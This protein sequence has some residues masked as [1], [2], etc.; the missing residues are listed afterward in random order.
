MNARR[1]TLTTAEQALF[2]TR[3]R[4]AWR[5]DALEWLEHHIAPDAP[6]ALVGEIRHRLHVMQ[7][8][9]APTG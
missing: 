1:T 9:P 5:V 3:Q 6:V 4:G 2:R 7:Q 8:P